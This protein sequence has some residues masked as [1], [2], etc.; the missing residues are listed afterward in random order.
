[1]LPHLTTSLHRLAAV[2]DHGLA[3]DEGGGIGAQPKDGCGDLL[4]PAHPSYRSWVST[5]W[6]PSRGV[7]E[8]PLDHLGVDDARADGVYANV[9]CRVVEGRALGRADDVEF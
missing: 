2:N 6:C 4:G 8:D 1:M 3:D 9:G 5:A 7:T